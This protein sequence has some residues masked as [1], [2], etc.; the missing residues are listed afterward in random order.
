MT[1]A[2]GPIALVAIVAAMFVAAADARGQARQRWIGGNGNWTDGTNWDINGIDYPDAFFDG[3]LLVENDG[4]ANV[5]GNVSQNSPEIFL[6]ANLDA[7]PGTSGT[8]NIASGGAL[9]VVANPNFDNFGGVTVGDNGGTG[10][11]TIATG[12]S[13]AM[14]GALTSAT[15][16]NFNSTI[17][18]NGTA[19]LSAASAFLDRRLVLNGFGVDFNVAG[20]LVLGLAGNHAWEI[21]AGGAASTISVGGNADLGGTL[22]LFSSGY[23]PAI[24][25]SFTL[26][27]STTVDFGEIQGA[28]FSF[29]DTSALTLPNA[30]ANFRVETI[31]GGDN[32]TLTVATL[33]Q[34]PILVVNRETGNVSI[35]NPGAAASIDFDAYAIRSANGSLVP[36]NWN[37]LEGAGT[38]SGQWLAANPQ[39]TGLSELN[40]TGSSTIAA[41]SALNLGNGV[42]NLQTPTAFGEDN[43]DIRFQLGRPSGE[44]IEG[45]VVYE[46]MPNNTL[47]LNVDPTT[48]QAQLVNPTAFDIEI[49]AYSITSQTGSLNSANG[50]PTMTWQSF[51]DS[52]IA[53][54]NWFEA[55]VNNFQLSELQAIGTTAIDGNFGTLLGLGTPFDTA[56]TT[57]LVFRFA[58]A[59]ESTFRTGTVVYG[60]LVTGPPTL[61]GDYN[62]DGVVDA[63]DYTVWRDTLGETG[64]G[65]AADGN[66]DLLVDAADY[67]LWRS[68]F[69]QSLAS[70]SMSLDAAAVPEPSSL[71]AAIMTGGI[72]LLVAR[73]RNG[74][75]RHR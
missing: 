18:L 56:G 1:R 61:V 68:N 52:G 2:F 35:V 30:G 62:G 33:E 59:G 44:L 75:A 13:L 69:G 46:G 6:G 38:P 17:T 41:S 25:D 36:G 50:S 67:A 4:V 51:A 60:G 55:N 16:A 47:V 5:T 19:Q 48:G 22:R 7:N 43:E 63:A 34:R 3:E 40:I 9:S 27:D 42:F 24:G 21:G 72:G 58:L 54:G 65:L 14:E 23:V 64:P 70:G 37:S 53:G 57:D 71:V 29:V 39:A 73:R 74:L 49:D 20:N 32:G 45:V 8:L 12:G 26:I 28:G 15:G 66:G 31:S 11:L 10:T